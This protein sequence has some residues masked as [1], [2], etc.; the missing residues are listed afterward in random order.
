MTVMDTLSGAFNFEDAE[1][2][3]DTIPTVQDVKYPCE[4]C[5]NESGP[6]SGRGRKPKRCATHKRQK[7]SGV[8]VTG[9]TSNLA[10]QAAKS[11]VQLNGF[12]AF[13][14]A[15]ARLFG[16]ASAIAG[17]QEMFEQQ[18]YAALITD[19]DLCRMIVQAGGKS[20]KLSLVL[21]YVGMGMAVAPTAMEEIRAL[22][23][24]REAREDEGGPRT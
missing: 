11:L 6:Y 23:A 21:A 17:Y 12:M 14:A 7:T 1:V 22:K 2:P 3:T 15:A 19:P 24:A 9:S 16:T 10:A 4:V 13:G 20:S 5:G 8:R 18:A